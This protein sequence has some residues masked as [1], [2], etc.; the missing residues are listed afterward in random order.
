MR[1]LELGLG[2][3]ERRRRRG[4]KSVRKYVGLENRFVLEG[5]RTTKGCSVLSSVYTLYMYLGKYPP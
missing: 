2:R 3:R 1:K 5:R 4:Y